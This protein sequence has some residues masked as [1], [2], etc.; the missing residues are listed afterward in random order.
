[1]CLC[2]QCPLEGVDSTSASVLSRCFTRISPVSAILTALCREGHR[3]CPGVVGTWY[4]ILQ[5]CCPGSFLSQVCIRTA[6]KMTIKA[7]YCWCQQTVKQEAGK[8]KVSWRVKWRPHIEWDMLML[9]VSIASSSSEMVAILLAADLY[10]T[11][12]KVIL[13]ISVFLYFVVLIIWSQAS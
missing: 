5:T 1:M 4:F 6:F 13:D 2:T 12:S 7:T 9:T 10:Q 3:E 8:F 11:L